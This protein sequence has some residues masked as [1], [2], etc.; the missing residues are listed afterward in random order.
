MIK[1]IIND[2]TSPKTPFR[3]NDDNNSETLKEF[4]FLFEE[5]PK[6]LN[7]L[8]KSYDDNGIPLNKSY[9]D[10]DSSE[11][12]YYPISIGQFGLAIF[13]SYIMSK[14]EDKKKHFLRIANWFM[15]NREEDEKLGCYWLTEVPKPEY[16]VFSPW[17]SAFTQSRAISIL[18]RAWQITKEEKYLNTCKKALVP[19]TY[20]INE[21]GVTAYLKKDKPFYEEYVASEPTMVVACPAFVF[22]GLYDFIRAV[23]QNVDIQ[24]HKLACKILNNGIEAYINWLPKFDLGYWV[25]YNYC[26]MSNFPQNNPCS[27]GYLRL[28][29]VEM[30]ILYKLSNRKEFLHFAQRFESYDKIPN[31][32]RMYFVKYKALK[33]LNRL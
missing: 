3:I 11:L 1:K 25:N 31:I 17:K 10:V 7:R 29:I 30:K 18:L 26:K 24:S 33:K 27:I 2:I 21:G 5:D 19:F 23:P 20:D 32:L 15:E 13:N 28:L 4:Y 6:K 14:S 22:F 12:T 16:N 9:I 8:I